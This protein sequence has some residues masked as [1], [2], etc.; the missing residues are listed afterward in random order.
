MVG[1]SG[2]SGIT[3][4]HNVNFVITFSSYNSDC[5]YELIDIAM[6]AANYL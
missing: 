6:L 2:Q 5:I 3:G 4:L 1:C